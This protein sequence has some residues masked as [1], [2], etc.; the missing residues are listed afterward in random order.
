MSFESAHMNYGN[1]VAA[2][3]LSAKQ[4]RL[5][6]MGSSGWDTTAA[7]ARADGVLQDKVVQGK[8][9]EVCI[10]GVTK[11]VLGGTVAKGDV[12]EADADGKAIPLAAGVAAGIALESGSAGDII[13][14]NFI[15]SYN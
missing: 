6:S 12:L 1:E 4:Y 8:A 5:V 15:A 14:M 7:A 3:D 10:S 9:C 11:I 2:N 13:A